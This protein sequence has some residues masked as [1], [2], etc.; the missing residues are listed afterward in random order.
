MWLGPHPS[1]AINDAY[2]DYCAV[3]RE[4]HEA[5]AL[6]Q[7]KESLPLAQNNVGILCC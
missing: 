6:L 5:V 7:P 4:Q 1:I 3:Q 2:Y